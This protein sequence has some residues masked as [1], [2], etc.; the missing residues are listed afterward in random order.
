MNNSKETCATYTTG[1]TQKKIRT[2]LTITPEIATPTTSKN[3]DED[4]F[5]ATT[6]TTWATRGQPEPLQQFNDIKKVGFYD[7]FFTT[8]QCCIF[9]QINTYL[10]FERKRKKETKSKN[11]KGNFVFIVLSLLLLFIFSVTI[12]RVNSIQIYFYFL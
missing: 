8:T 4:F 10:L 12:L 3:S 1:H 6:T 9:I 5:R 2:S 11:E 7:W